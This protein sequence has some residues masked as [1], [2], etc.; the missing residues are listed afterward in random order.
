M[1]YLAPII[2]GIIIGQAVNKMGFEIITWQ[3]WVIFIPLTIWVIVYR[4]IDDYIKSLNKGCKHGFEMSDVCDLKKDPKCKK[5]GKS[6]S[7]LTT[8]NK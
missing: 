4:D 8:K 7:E 2:N 3:Y 5:C 6:L 1:N